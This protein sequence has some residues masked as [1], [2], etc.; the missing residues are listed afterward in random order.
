M[1]ILVLGG[2]GFIGPYVVRQLK[3][4]GHDL[5]LF[6]RGSRNPEQTA[7]ERH[8]F[9]DRKRLRDF[10]AGLRELQPEVVLDMFPLSGKDAEDVVETFNGSSVRRIVAISSQD[11]YRGYA[12]LNRFEE[13]T[14]E[15]I[16]F[17]EDSPLRKKLYP[18]RGRIKGMDDYDK[19]PAERIIMNTPGLAGTVMR[20]PMVYGPGDYQHRMFNFLKRM[21]D[22]RPAI[23]L[24]E[25][26]SRWRW[27]RGYVEDVASAIAMA[28]EDDLAAGRIYNVGEK[29]ACTMAE[30]V[31]KIGRASGWNG[32]VA[33]VP[34]RLLPP[35]MTPDLNTS[36]HLIADTG[37]IREELGFRERAPAD[38]AIE[39]TAAW[40]KANPPGEI[41]PDDFDYK[42]EDRVIA[43]L[44]KLEN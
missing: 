14:P 16:P 30:W 24:E 23:L 9:G 44:E 18:Y 33:A 43:S 10:A 20:L 26:Y 36:Q 8:I 31:E 4:S 32:R 5:T 38:M 28:V 11:V 1:K 12:I 41:D 21:D 13:D 7:G 2:T 17:H 35:G 42:A 3:K 6:H 40:E 25:S 29:D 15:D 22:G 34:A 19:I 39:K 27:T 37:R